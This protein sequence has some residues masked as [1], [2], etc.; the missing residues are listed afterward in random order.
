MPITKSAIKA[1]RQSE[2]RR[3]RNLA[4]KQELQKVLKSFSRLMK[5]KKTDEAKAFF[6]KV[7]KALDKAAK[8]GILKK[9]SS[10]R[11]KS[12]LAL[13]LQK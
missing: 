12:R 6:P 7:Q 10:S 8:K 9:N 13:A 4:K 11:K 1:K 2:R 5:E 3:V